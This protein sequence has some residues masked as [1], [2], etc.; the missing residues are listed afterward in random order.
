M[1]SWKMQDRARKEAQRGAQQAHEP[2]A[3]MALDGLVIAKPL[4]KALAICESCRHPGSVVL[5][6][7]DPS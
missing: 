2:F 3:V 4:R 1:R 5:E 6:E 7:V